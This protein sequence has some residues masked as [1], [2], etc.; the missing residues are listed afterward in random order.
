MY[1]D[2]SG[3]HNKEIMEIGRIFTFTE[4]ISKLE[5]QYKNMKI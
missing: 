1:D 5:V 2:E 3:L 4:S